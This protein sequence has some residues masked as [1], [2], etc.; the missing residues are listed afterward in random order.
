MY[1][2]FG[3]MFKAILSPKVLKLNDLVGRTNLSD[4]Q[5]EALVKEVE[6]LI[7]KVKKIDYL[8]RAGK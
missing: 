7:A 8:Q 5:Q 1:N 4:K 2:N 6:D 3:T